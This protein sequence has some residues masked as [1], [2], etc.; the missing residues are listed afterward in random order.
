MGKIKNCEQCG[1]EFEDKH[2]DGKRFCSRS[3]A[4]VYNSSRRVFPDYSGDKNPNWKGVSLTP[5]DNCGK[6]IGK[7][8]A[9]RGVGK[10]N[11]CSKKCYGKH[12]TK[13][14]TVV[15][16]CPICKKSFTVHKHEAN[17]GRFCSVQCAGKDPAEKERKSRMHKGKTISEQHRQ[18]VSKAMSARSSE[19]E[20]SYGK[21]GHYVSVKAG[22][23]FYRSSYERIAY[24][25]LDADTTVIRYQPEPF[26]IA[27]PNSEGKI[28]RYRPDILVEKRTGK[29]VLIE[30]KPRWK[31]GDRNTRLKLEAGE[32]YAKNNG[33]TFEVWTEKELKIAKV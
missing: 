22:N 12:L 30:V 5:C 29:T 3:C 26:V 8:I 7:S 23:I 2:R 13:L 32:R 10:H 20:F 28:R 15:L 31:M 21:N 25:M 6:P 14:K 16:I 18:A 4:G 17:D 9:D 27:Y 1:K 11:Y 19:K 24:E 33:W